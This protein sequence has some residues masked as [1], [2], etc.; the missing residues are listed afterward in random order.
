MTLLT[1]YPLVPI[2]MAV[3]LCSI[4]NTSPLCIA[5]YPVRLN[6]IL[7]RCR[8]CPLKCKSECLSLLTM[9]SFDFVVN[10]IL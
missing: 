9:N 7:P 3:L 2:L 1:L 10:L 8:S 4:G 5:M 6:R